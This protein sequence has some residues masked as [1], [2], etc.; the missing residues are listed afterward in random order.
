MPMTRQEIGDYLGL[1]LETVS[2]SFGALRRAGLIEM[3]GSEKF[4]FVDAP[5]AAA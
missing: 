2:R 5:K 1:S 3:N 4:R